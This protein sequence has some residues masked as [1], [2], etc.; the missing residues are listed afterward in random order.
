MMAGAELSLVLDVII[1]VLLAGTIFFAARLSVHLKLFRESRSALD[2]LIGD[3][4]SHIDKADA[5]IEGLR[6]TAKDSGRDLQALIN[7]SK[8]L[9][10]ELQLMG[11][12]GNNLAGRLE[13]LA[14]RSGNNATYRR[15]E[16]VSSH[17]P[18]D[19]KVDHKKE[20]GTTLFHIRDPEFEDNI[21][22]ET[23]E[24]NGLFTAEEDDDMPMPESLQSRAEQE[25]Y[26]ALHS[27]NGNVKIGSTP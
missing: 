5:A 14:E 4:A 13:K 2:K 11:E 1:L 27:R 17:V 7:E 22:D 24:E 18:D 20:T 23:P 25:L 8:A 12:A 10:D 3:L 19:H 21:L 26:E 16:T 15:M 6:A 9:F